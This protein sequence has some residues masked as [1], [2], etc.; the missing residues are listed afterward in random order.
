MYYPASLSGSPTP[1]T[2]RVRTGV[3]MPISIQ[4]TSFV[5]YAPSV[6]NKGTPGPGFEDEVETSGIFKCIL[7]L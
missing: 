6:F 2:V 4:A 3:K 1:F 5:N 7:M